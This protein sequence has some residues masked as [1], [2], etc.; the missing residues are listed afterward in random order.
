MGA[1]KAFPPKYQIKM[2]KKILIVSVLLHI[3]VEGLPVF[4]GLCPYEYF[5]YCGLD[6]NGKLETVCA[7]GGLDIIPS[8][9]MAP[10]LQ[11]SCF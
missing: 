2:Y 7:N 3:G 11:V 10:N 1:Q 5:C 8:D 6:K 4:D 9:K